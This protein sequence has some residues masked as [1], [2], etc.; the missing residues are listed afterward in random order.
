MNHLLHGIAVLG[1]AALASCGDADSAASAPFCD[2]T[3]LQEDTLKYTLEHPEK[4]YVY[5]TVSNCLPDTVIWTHRRIENRLKIDFDEMAEPG[6]RIHP[7]NIA[8]H[9]NDT[10]YAWLEFNDCMT[11][12]GYLAK[13]NFNKRAGR[14]R[15]TSAL[16]RF[17]P[18]YRIADG[19]IAYADYESI[20]VEDIMTGKTE[21]IRLGTEK[22]EVD[23]TKM[24]D[25]FDSVN[26]TRTRI[27]VNL[28]Q[29][30]KEKA[31]EKNISL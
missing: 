29:K 27:F 10:S 26:I 28:V 2:T 5:I 30:G 23:W 19:L 7:K 24:Q 31:L 20:Y 8:C 9:F 1:F 15:Y 14:S 17:N 18:H 11:G 13:L 22:I 3:C 6:L 16:T 25:T 12:R 21:K 4:P